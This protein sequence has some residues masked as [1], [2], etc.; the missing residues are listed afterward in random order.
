MTELSGL[1][2]RKAACE[3]LGLDRPKTLDMGICAVVWS[4]VCMTGPSFKFHD[5]REFRVPPGETLPQ[6]EGSSDWNDRYALFIGRQLPEEELAR[7]VSAYRVPVGRLPAI[8]SDPAVSETVFEEFCEKN[9]WQWE[10]WRN[11]HT[12]NHGISLRL[13][14]NGRNIALYNNDRVYGA[15]P[16]EARARSILAALTSKSEGSVEAKS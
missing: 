3:A 15:T 9:G 4:K 11:N 12:P 13:S 16:S 6:P 14:Q 8:E 2:L 7:E 1:D 10:M 5:G